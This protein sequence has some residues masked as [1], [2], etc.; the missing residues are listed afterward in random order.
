MMAPTGIPGPVDI[1]KCCCFVLYLLGLVVVWPIAR[2][3]VSNTTVELPYSVMYPCSTPYAMLTNDATIHLPGPFAAVLKPYNT[4]LSTDGVDGAGRPIRV[5][6]GA[7]TFPSMSLKHGDNAVD[8]TTGVALADTKSLLES[9]ILPMF[10]DNKTVKLYIDVPDLSLDV[11]GL[12]PV[13][14][15]QMHKVLTCRGTRT[16]APKEIPDE[17]CHPADASATALLEEANEIMQQMVSRRLQPSAKDQYQGYEMKC[18]LDGDSEA[19]CIWSRN[20]CIR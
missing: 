13:P 11:F 15:L 16:T 3:I 4:T 9:F 10:V 19:D 20:A 18:G 14:K 8:F 7:A 17:Y 6:I 5:N 12:F 2:L 1:I